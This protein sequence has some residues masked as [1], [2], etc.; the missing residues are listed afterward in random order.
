MSKEVSKLVQLRKLG[1]LQTIKDSVGNRIQAKLYTQKG[2]KNRNEDGELVGDYKGT[3]LLDAKEFLSPIW[4]DGQWCWGSTTQE[5]ADIMSKLKLRYPK[6]HRNEGQEI[7]ADSEPIE[8]RL[9]NFYDDFF[10]HPSF[11]GKVYMEDGRVNLNMSDP[12]HKFLY[13]CWKAEKH[14]KD[15][16]N[17]AP[18]NKYIAGTKRYEITSHE[19]ENIS[20]KQI[21]DKQIEA[22]KILASLNGDVTKQKAI[23]LVMD[24]STYNAKSDDLNGLF[25]I[26]SEAAQDKSTSKKYGG[27]T[28]QD[29]FIEVGKMKPEDLAIA[30]VVIQG[31]NLGI[32]RNRIDHILLNGERIGEKGTWDDSKIIKFFTRDENQSKYLE[33]QD[34]VENAS[35]R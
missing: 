14:T 11:Y 7:R 23:A 31:K 34:L 1:G 15:R 5:L 16:A 3:T 12:V 20:K 13:Y 19:S 24:L 4:G 25:L 28:I 18:M 26:L 9:T 17:N 22:I 29:R 35:K 30:S 21:V 8:S 27:I 32:I 6:G 2:S 33:L 10:R